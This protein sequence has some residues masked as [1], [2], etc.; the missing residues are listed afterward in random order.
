MTLEW[1]DGT[2]PYICVPRTIHVQAQTFFS[3]FAEKQRF[4]LDSMKNRQDLGHSLL[5]D[6]LAILGH[7]KLDAHMLTSMTL[8]TQIAGSLW[9]PTDL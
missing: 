7:R 9:E 5:D 4:R 2:K 8:V 6:S 1:T 3:N